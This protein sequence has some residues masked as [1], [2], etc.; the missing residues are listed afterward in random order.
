MLGPEPEPECEWLRSISTVTAFSTV[1]FHKN[2]F[3]FLVKTV[4][5][6]SR[7]FNIIFRALPRFVDFWSNSMPVVFWNTFFDLFG[8]HINDL[9]LHVCECVT[10]SLCEKHPH[11]FSRNFHLNQ[12]HRLFH[13]MN[14]MSLTRKTR[15]RP[16]NTGNFFSF[17]YRYHFWI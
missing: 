14:E 17:R 12:N 6:E 11:F 1:S 4:C 3:Y 15:H 9:R 2:V 13:F 8:L 5:I 7:T 10:N 16:G